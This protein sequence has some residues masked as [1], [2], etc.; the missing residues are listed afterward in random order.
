MTELAGHHDTRHRIGCVSWSALAL[1]AS[2]FG[3]PAAVS[4]AA[5]NPAW[6]CEDKSGPG[7]PFVIVDSAA[8]QKPGVPPSR[9]ESIQQA[10]AALPRSGR[11]AIYLRTGAYRLT[12]SLVLGPAADDLTIAACPGEIPVLESDDD[13]PVLVL[14][15]AKNVTLIGLTFGAASPA[16]IVLEDARDCTIARDTFVRGGTAIRLIGSSGNSI[17]HNLIVHPAATGV[18]LSD[19]SDGNVLADNIIDGAGALET[20]GGGIFIHGGHFNRIA[21]NLVQNA[22]G[23]GIGVSNWDDSTLNVGNVV[24]FN[25]LRDTALTAQDSGAIYV[26]G[27]SGADTQIVIAG[28][29]IDGAGTGGEHVVGIYLDD[30]TNGAVVTHNLVRRAGSYA[31]QIHGGS[32]NLVVNNLMD[33][34]DGHTAAVLF[35][36]APADTNP[37]NTQTGNEVVRNV[38]LSASKDPVLF[39]WIDGG[40][41]YIANN[42]YANSAGDVRLPVAPVAD[43]QP[44]I[45]D[46]SIV[47][48]AE[49]DHYEAAQTAA[50]GIGF[51]AVDFSAIGPRARWDNRR[52]GELPVPQ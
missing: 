32:D 14:R 24:E 51:V 35:Q 34:G 26:L 16:Q 4:A 46:P 10:L 39:D 6:T 37:L 52:D 47:R 7:I 23:F 9:V 2:V 42:L 41:P 11:R 30:S 50:A 28:N 1:A 40:T 22:S 31:V 20:H 27:R 21:H 25:L 33:L 18:E 48:D 38:I 45:G 19:G 15:A 29:V 8:A 12:D 49:R 17:R 13:A 5:A 3:F 44:V 36:A 43:V